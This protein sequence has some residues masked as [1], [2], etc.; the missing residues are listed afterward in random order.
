MS[1]D[2]GG[3]VPPGETVPVTTG[4]V[5]VSSGTLVVDSTG[6]EVVPMGAD[7][8]ARDLFVGDVVMSVSIPATT[9]GESVTPPS[10]DGL[11]E[12]CADPELSSDVGGGVAAV[13]ENVPVTIGVFVVSTG[14]LVAGT[15]S[16]LIATR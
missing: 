5:V 13:G 1:I 16:T 10:I 8:V 12:T 4:V 11:T 7:V 9:E 6:M 15:A 2:V 3:G 14:A